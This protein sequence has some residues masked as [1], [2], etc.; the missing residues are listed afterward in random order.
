M[1]LVILLP[2]SEQI[3]WMKKEFHRRRVREQKH[4]IEL[5]KEAVKRLKLKKEYTNKIKELKE[6]IH[7]KTGNEYF[8]KMHS[9]KQENN[10]LVK[11]N[12]FDMEKN[13]RLMAKVDL[14]IVKMEKKMKKTM[15]VFNPTKIIFVENQTPVKIQGEQEFRADKEKLLAISKCLEALYKMKKQIQHQI[16]LHNGTSVKRY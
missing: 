13:K 4:G 1:K 9:V 12:K 6:E 10:K 15:P 3:S 11:I 16:R 2:W 5:R 8:F 14:E 7:F